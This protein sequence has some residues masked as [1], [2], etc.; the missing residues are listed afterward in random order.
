MI[1]EHD[2]KEISESHVFLAQN[3]AGIYLE[4]L[5]GE[6]VRIL[7]NEVISRETIKQLE[8]E[9]G[10]YKRAYAGLEAERIRNEQLIQDS[11]KKREDLENICQGHRVIALLDGDG[12]IFNSQLIAQGQSGGHIAAQKLSDAIMQHLAST[13][14]VNRYQLWVYIF[15]NRR[16]LVDTFGRV[17]LAA[18]KTKF[19]EF[20]MGFNQAA[21]RFL[22]LDVGSAKEAA[23]AKIKA[24]L[25]DEIRLPQTEKIIFGGC[26]DNGY[27]TTIRSHITA[28]FKNKLTL[29]RSYTDMAAGMNEL[30]LPSFTIPD[31]F[32]SQ[33]LGMPTPPSHINSIPVHMPTTVPTPAV[34]PPVERPKSHRPSLSIIQQGFDALPFASIEPEDPCRKQPPQPP[35]YSSA[36]QTLPKRAATPELDSSGSTTCDESEHGSPNIPQISLTNSRSRRINPNIVSVKLRKYVSFPANITCCSSSP[37][38]YKPPPCTLFYLSTCKH[39]VDCKYGHDY[40]LQPEHYAEIRANAKKSPCPSRNKGKQDISLLGSRYTDKYKL[41]DICLW[42]DDCCYGHHCPMT[43]KCHFFKQ[44]RCKFQGGTWNFFHLGCLAWTANLGAFDSVSLQ[45]ICIRNLRTNLPIWRTR[46]SRNLSSA[47]VRRNT[48]LEN[49]VA[50]LEVELS[51][52]KQAHS[53]ALEASERESKAHNV[54]LAALNRQISNLDSFKNNNN[55]LILCII[56]G[57]EF[58]FNRDLLNQG[59]QGG[60]T[61]AQHLTQA[62]AEQLSGEEVHVFGRLSFWITIY[63]NKA[64][65]A[66]DISG[67][68]ICTQDQ[69]QAFLSNIFKSSL[70]SLK[71]FV[72]SLEVS[73]TALEKDQMLGKIVVLY[74]SHTQDNNND[75]PNVF[76]L[77]RLVLDGLFLLEKL[78]RAPKK[79][80][81]LSTGPYSAVTSNGGLISPQSPP[82]PPGRPIDPSLPLHKRLLLLFNSFTRVVV[83]INLSENPPPCNEFYLMTCSKGAGVC[84]YSHDYNLT[85]DQL[86]S[87]AN[88]AKKAPCNWLKNGIDL[89]S[90]YS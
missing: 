27:V 61:A 56:N 80:A 26:H 28:G 16:G 33:K 64:E 70:V 8:N 68:G 39:G 62:I 58:V 2:K 46:K 69:F 17:G 7:D 42:G 85:S 59:Y 14:G 22:M 84:K 86:V 11:Q 4:Q 10:V 21:E 38:V 35:S 40:L 75:R 9:L 49:R 19:D 1:Y 77:P 63:L 66:E 50:E 72:S 88:N 87:L 15:L 44:N 36:V 29:L 32:I 37:S 23:D 43:T 30:E 78:P 45:L 24:L 82:R 71:L 52:W 65:L 57:D 67:N 53:V 47:T 74:T 18:A 81:P 60:R 34:P 73:N 5:R 76:S 79:L 51:V 20:I 6:I 55:A 89:L 83:L 54:Q 13:N 48:D 31:L 12:A 3:N 25:E 41:G 90:V